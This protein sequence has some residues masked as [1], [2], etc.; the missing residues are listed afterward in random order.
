MANLDGWDLAIL[1]VAAY[2]AIVTLVRLMRHH[3][4]A[5]VAKLQLQVAIEQRRKRA[6]EHRRRTQRV[7]ER[8]VRA[9]QGSIE[10][11]S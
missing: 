7:I 9:P 4:D 3:R 2:V 1:G 6:A 8:Q 11:E 5:V 10:S